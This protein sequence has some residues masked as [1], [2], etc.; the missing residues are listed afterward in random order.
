MS[1]TVTIF[2]SVSLA[3]AIPVFAYPLYATLAIAALVAGGYLHFMEEKRLNNTDEFDKRL[4][5]LER[6]IG[7]MNTRK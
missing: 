1:R 4:S 5:A 6:Q 3:L 2:F 7:F